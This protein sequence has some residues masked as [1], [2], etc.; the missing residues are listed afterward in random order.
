MTRLTKFLNGIALN[1]AA[2]EKLFELNFVS[3]PFYK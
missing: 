1:E 3:L 2:E